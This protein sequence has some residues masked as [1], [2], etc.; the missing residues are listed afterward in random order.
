MSYARPH[1]RALL[2]ICVMIALTV[3]LD[4]LR[5]WPTKILVDHVLGNE[6]LT[7][8][9]LP[10][11]GAGGTA[12]LL[13]WAC[14]GTVLIYASKAAVGMVFTAASVTFGQRMVYSLAADT[15]AHSQRLSLLYH[16]RRQ[17]GDLVHRVTVDS[18]CVQVLIAS[19][20]LPLV[21]SVLTLGAMFVIMWRL[22]A[23]LTLVSLSV[24]PFLLALTWAFS[25]PMKKLSRRRRDLEGQ[26]MSLVEQT[27]GAIPAVQAFTREEFESDRFRRTAADTV[28][29][30][31]HSTAVD[32]WFKTLAGLVTALGTAGIMW[33]GGT[34]ALEGRISVGTILVFLAYLACLYEP[35]N[36]V[37][38]TASLIQYASA[39]ADRVREVRDAPVDV[40]DAPEARD[41]R[42]KGQVRFRD[43][44]FGYGPEPVLKGI[45]LD[46]RPGE[47]IAIVGPTGAGKTTLVNLLL[48]FFDPWSGQVLIDGVDARQL[49]VR[50]LREQVAIV[51]QESFLLP[52]SVADNL[53]YG[54][55][56]ATREEIIAAAQAANADSFIRSLPDGY[57]SVIGER[58]ATLSG[59]EKQRLA[60][61]R[62]LLK[63]APILILD[64]PTSALDARTEALLMGAVAKLMDGRTTFIIAHR[65]STIRNAD[66]IVVLEGG[67]L[68]EEGRHEDLLKKNG[69]YARLY[70]QQ[71]DIV[72]HDGRALSPA[73]VSLA[74]PPGKG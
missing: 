37:V 55:P 39:G 40:Q 43:V 2:V 25:R 58:G 66:R 60:I 5:P 72:R 11:L 56:N 27:L 65:L 42:V 20:L 12:G 52:L 70:H 41:V 69:L 31:R 53:A 61:A 16:S 21:Q 68:V 28:A 74:S 3:V 47:T 38:Y 14:A 8:P 32:V 26:M 35:L 29:A 57:D 34:Y 62:A 44:T 59:G 17:L 67:Q 48:R 30:Y 13:F 18:Y 36:S 1:W 51:L 63:G 54:R 46:A 64:E 33:L 50:S 24:V 23:T 15:F 49:K 45:T 9:W 22:E 7:G 19:T 4:V 6:A 73:F 71:L 10:V